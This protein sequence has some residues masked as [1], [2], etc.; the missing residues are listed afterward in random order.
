MFINNNSK[1]AARRNDLLCNTV[2]AGVMHSVSTFWH[3]VLDRSSLHT[4]ALTFAMNR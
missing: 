2:A 3:D 1:N 4:V